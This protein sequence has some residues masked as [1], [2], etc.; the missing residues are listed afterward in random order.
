MLL[1]A[2]FPGIVA[3]TTALVATFVCR[4]LRL[5]PQI[6][7]AIGFS[8]AYI[9][10]QFALDSRAAGWTWPSL[11][12]PLEARDWLPAAVLLSLAWTILAASAPTNW[13]FRLLALATL[14]VVAVPARLLAG[15]VAQR[16][17]TAE[18]LFH[19]GL[20]SAAF[21]LLWLLL[22]SSRSHE[23]PRTRAALAALVAAVAAIVMT[24]SGSFTYGQ[25]G[26]AVAGAILGATVGS[27]AGPEGA[28]GPITF[29]LGSL[30]LLSCYYAQLTAVSAAL[31]L[32]ALVLAA[33]RVPNAAAT[34]PA[35][36]Q[37]AI[38]AAVCMFLLGVALLRAG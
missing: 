7:W 14:L 13:R 8:L 37:A 22:S 6:A 29:S 19:L 24:L 17:S 20:L 16:W 5:P 2:I 34:L 27:A 25:L 15:P 35:W 36:L 38:R 26:A 23:Q 21:G 28:A 12:W 9:A 10:A 11:L 1:E 32:L 30:V 3:F 18:K 31:L 33:A 4:R